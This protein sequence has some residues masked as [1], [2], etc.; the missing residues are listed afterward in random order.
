M[1][2]GEQICPVLVYEKLNDLPHIQQKAYHL[3]DP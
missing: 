2:P 1:Q 3:I